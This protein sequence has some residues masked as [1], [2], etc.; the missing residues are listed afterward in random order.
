MTQLSAGA[1]NSLEVNPDQ[2]KRQV[3]ILHLREHIILKSADVSA[4]SH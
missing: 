1:A 4:S 3:C 2:E